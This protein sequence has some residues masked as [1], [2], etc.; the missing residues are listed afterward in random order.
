M[1]IGKPDFDFYNSSL[2]NRYMTSIYYTLLMIY[3]AD[4]GPATLV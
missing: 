4:I 3:G 1:N 2:Y